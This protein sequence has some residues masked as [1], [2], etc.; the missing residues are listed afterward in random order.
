MMQAREISRELQNS[1]FNI[2][3]QKPHLQT[4]L[5]YHQVLDFQMNIK[6]QQ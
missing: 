3:F 5:S 6:Q 2:H 4:P 1:V